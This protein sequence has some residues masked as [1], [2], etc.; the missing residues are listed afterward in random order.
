MYVYWYLFFFLS[1][2]LFIDSGFFNATSIF[3]FDT[4]SAYPYYFGNYTN[5]QEL[6]FNDTQLGSIF[7]T[8]YF[9]NKTTSM[10]SAFSNTTLLNQFATLYSQYQNSIPSNQFSSVVSAIENQMVDYAANPNIV[11]I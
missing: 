8:C 5:F 6:V 9:T 3:A 2:L 11:T 1:L 4:C 7:S 10:F